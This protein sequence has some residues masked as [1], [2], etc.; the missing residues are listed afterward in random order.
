MRSNKKKSNPAR[1]H[2]YVPQ[3]LLKHFADDKGML[4]EYDTETSPKISEKADSKP[5][6]CADDSKGLLNSPNVLV[7]EP[8]T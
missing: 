7:L 3:C 5:D 1:N 6:A 2:H 8:P 4:W